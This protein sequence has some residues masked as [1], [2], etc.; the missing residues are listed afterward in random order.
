MNERRRCVC[1]RQDRKKVDQE[2]GEAMCSDTPTGEERLSGWVGQNVQEAE[3]DM[4]FF[5]LSLLGIDSKNMRF[6]GTWTENTRGKGS[7][8]LHL[9]NHILGKMLIYILIVQQNTSNVFIYTYFSAFRLR[10][11]NYLRDKNRK[12]KMEMQTLAKL[13]EKFPHM[14][15]SSSSWKSRLPLCSCDPCVSVYNDFFTYLHLDMENKI[16]CHVIYF[17]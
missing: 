17:R 2:P 9:S 13:K 8:H 14:K 7:T 4:L 16:T 6:P 15:V 11:E 5:I 1:C 12:K 10:V 3:H